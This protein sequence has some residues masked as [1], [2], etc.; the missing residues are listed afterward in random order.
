M[1]KGFTLIE[2]LAVITIIAIIAL[3]ATPLVNNFIV[4]GQKNSFLDSVNGIVRTVELDNS[5]MDYMP[6]DYEITNGVIKN[7]N[8]GGTLKSEGGA[9][10]SGNISIN[11][12][13][14][15]S[16]AIHNNR[17]CVTKDYTGNRNIKEYIGNC[18]IS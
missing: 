17:W 8:T 4:N 14:K 1:K 15:I 11:S 7:K 13:G 9:D 18:E 5:S 16:Y 2:L 3:I 6:A 10:E 12:D